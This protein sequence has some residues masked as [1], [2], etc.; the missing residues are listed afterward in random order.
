MSVGSANSTRTPPE[1]EE[2]VGFN[3]IVEPNS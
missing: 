1:E 2:D 3:K